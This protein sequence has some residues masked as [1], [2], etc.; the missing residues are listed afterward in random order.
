MRKNKKKK[1]KVELEYLQDP[2]KVK[3]PEILRPLYEA[4]EKL[5]KTLSPGNVGKQAKGLAKHVTKSIKKGVGKKWE[6]GG[7]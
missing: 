3:D 6:D 2:K 7:P 1:K 4:D 5:R